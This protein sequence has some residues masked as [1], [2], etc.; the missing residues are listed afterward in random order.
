VA[1]RD[2]KVASL[3]CLS[4]LLELFLVI[5]VLHHVFIENI[6]SAENLEYVKQKIFSVYSQTLR[7]SADNHEVHWV[8]CGNAVRLNGR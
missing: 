6:K 8:W 7:L 2:C 1:L 5:F 3:L 4:V